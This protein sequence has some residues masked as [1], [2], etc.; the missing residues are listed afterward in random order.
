MSQQCLDLPGMILA[1]QLLN[2]STTGTE[3]DWEKRL[4]AAR[5]TTGAP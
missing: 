3:H 2:M 5:F 4:G 1:H